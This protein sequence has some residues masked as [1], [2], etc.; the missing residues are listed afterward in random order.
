MPKGRSVPSVDN[1]DLRMRFLQL[2][3]LYD[4]A[5]SLTSERTELD[6]VEELLTRVCTIT[7]PASAVAVTRGTYG[8]VQSVASVGCSEL[9]PNALLRSQVW[10]D[11]MERGGS[12]RHQEGM[13]AGKEFA[14]ALS[15]PFGYRGKWYGFITLFDKETRTGDPRF[16]EDDQRFLESVAALGGAVVNASRQVERLRG[17]RQLLEEEN[18]ALKERL[19]SDV[20]GRRIIAQTPNMRR[21]LEMAE[22]IAPRRVS[23]LIQGESGTGKELVARLIHMQSKREGPLVT[24]NCAAIPET[25]LESELFGIAKG[26]ATGV[27]ARRGKFEL[28]H[29]GTL[30]LD[31]IGDMPLTLQ[32]KLLRVLQER[33][34]TPVGSN[35][36]KT[37]DVR[38][39][40]ATHQDLDNHLG[41]SFRQDLYYRLRGVAIHLPP[42]RKRREDIPHLVRHFAT[43]FCEREDIPLAKFTSDA[44]HLLLGHPWPG[45]IRELQ[46]VVEAA[47][48][49]ADGAIDAHLLQSLLS[50]SEQSTDDPQ[51]LHLEAAKKR[52]ITKVLEITKGNRTAAARILGIN[53]RTLNR[54]GF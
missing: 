2:E 37:V 23:V 52:H 38:F 51:N 42:L 46:N 48:S 47:V 50:H 17:E 20:G 40:A 45:N 36:A 53:R 32:V 9:E 21:V 14:E 18:R 3:A 15:S 30:F 31:E 27:D 41:K 28:A 5:L 22:R 44:T 34:I 16:T 49:L 33:E 26:V 6:L 19:T 13:L 29:E 8:E 10:S 39:L 25:L 1:L 12:C 35:K 24:V 43:E 54:L 4:L 11:I 7:D